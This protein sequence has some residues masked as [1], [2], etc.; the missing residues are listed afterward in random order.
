MGWNTKAGMTVE[1]EEKAQGPSYVDLMGAESFS[2]AVRGL[3]HLD[4]CMLPEKKGNCCFRG[5]WD[6]GNLP[7]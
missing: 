6:T 1:A 5:N 2:W 3:G 7:G 4:W